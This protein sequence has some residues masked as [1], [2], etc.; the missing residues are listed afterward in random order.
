M[1]PK[2]V[3]KLRAS[4]NLKALPKNIKEYYHRIGEFHHKTHGTKISSINLLKEKYG[5][6]G[7]KY[8]FFLF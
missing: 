5:L 6:K 4:S 3:E 8:R 2:Q 7:W 1:T